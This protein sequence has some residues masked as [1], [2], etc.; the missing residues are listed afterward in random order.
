MVSDRESEFRNKLKEMLENEPGNVGYGKN[1][2]REHFDRLLAF[3]ERKPFIPYEVEIQPSSVCNA[4]CKHCFSKE[5]T[6]G[7]LPN[8]LCEENNL[9][10]IVDRLL[11][12]EVNEQKIESI[13][14]VGS[15]GDPLCNPMTLDAV[16][17][18]NKTGRVV[19]L[20]TNGI[21]LNY[22]DKTNSGKKYLDRLYVLDYMRWSLDAGNWWT[23]ALVKG[24]EESLVCKE[25]RRKMKKRFDE[26][27]NSVRKLT[28]LK[29]KFNP[30]MHIEAGY[31]IT[32]DNCDEIYEACKKAKDAGADSIRYRRN[33]IESAPQYYP[34]KIEYLLS[35]AEKEN[36]DKFK[37]IIVHMGEEFGGNTQ[38]RSFIYKRCYVPFFWYTAGSDGCSYPCGH[39]AGD[40]GWNLGSLL[41]GED[42]PEHFQ[43]QIKNE[44][45]WSMPDCD[46]RV[47]PPYAARLNPLIDYIYENRDIPDIKD[48]LRDVKDGVK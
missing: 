2:F 4:N 33:L 3:I 1:F 40:F 5:T 23:W 42:F 34:E 15:S 16:E 41:N 18:I 6:K 28:E 8:L 24:F 7:R 19:K 43:N 46:C 38:D 37:A 31:V 35:L 44:R 45:S 12:A 22:D 39:R 25:G 13:K 26:M 10:A 36:N 17:R 9:N 21:G 30:S 14:F 27:F 32:N 20:F 48:I 29:R 47:C 11:K